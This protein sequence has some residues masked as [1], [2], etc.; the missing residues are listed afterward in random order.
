MGNKLPPEEEFSSS[1]ELPI[2]KYRC[3]KEALGLDVVKSF[4]R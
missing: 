3:F 2:A 1:N 4:Y